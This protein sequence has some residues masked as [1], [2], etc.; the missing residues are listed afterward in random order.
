MYHSAEA[1]DDSDKSLSDSDDVEATIKMNKSGGV[2]GKLLPPPTTTAPSALL[3][4]TSPR[5]A[6]ANN[7][8][9]V[10]ETSTHI[11]RK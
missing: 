2:R 11:N 9:N 3:S 7:N 5:S 8:S 10:D 1:D 4:F 6:A